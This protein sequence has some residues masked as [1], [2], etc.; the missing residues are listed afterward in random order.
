MIPALYMQLA[1]MYMPAHILTLHILPGLLVAA[2][3]ALSAYLGL[4]LRPR[5]R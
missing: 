3:C 5:P 4:R 2:I 1:C